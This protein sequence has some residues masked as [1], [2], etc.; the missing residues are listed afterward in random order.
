VVEDNLPYHLNEAKRVIAIT[1][2][3]QRAKLNLLPRCTTMHFYSIK[4]AHPRED[5]K[6]MAEMKI[7]PMIATKYPNKSSELRFSTIGRHPRP[8]HLVTH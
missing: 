7:L 6:M 2:C 1:G 3:W 4:S 5:G 8:K